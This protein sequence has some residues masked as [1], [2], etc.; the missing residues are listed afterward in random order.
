MYRATLLLLILAPAAAQDAPASEEDGII[1]G[2]P[3]V[4]PELIG[5]LDSLQARAVY[6]EAARRD[7]VEGT[8]VVQFVVTEAGA[9]EGAEVVRS[10]D[11]RLN[12]AALDAVRASQFVPGE[13][14]E[15]PIRVHYAAPV[16][17]RLGDAASGD[18]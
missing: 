17:F 14:R 13:Q 11:E 16:A 18:R 12:E 8:V 10:P 1:C 7:G 4:Q 15:R 6:P 5:G 3:E 2:L 9:V